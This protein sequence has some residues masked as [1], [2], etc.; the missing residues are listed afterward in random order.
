MQ[1]GNGNTNP[2]AALEESTAIHAQAL[3][4]PPPAAAPQ[5]E[6]AKVFSLYVTYEYVDARGKRGTDFAMFEEVFGFGS[7]LDTPQKLAMAM[8]LIMQSKPKYKTIVLGYER[9][10]NVEAQR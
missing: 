9:P 2:R 7:S 8:Q 1:N 5:A 6:P 3:L 4:P 10:L